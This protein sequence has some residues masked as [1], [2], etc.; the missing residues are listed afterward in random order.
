MYK[1]PA[2]CRQSCQTALYPGLRD[3]ARQVH[4]IGCF[5]DILQAFLLIFSV[6]SLESFKSKHPVDG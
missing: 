5:N 1:L 3:I 6:K 4:P 2:F